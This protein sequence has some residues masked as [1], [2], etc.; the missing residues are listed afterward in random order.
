MFLPILP[1]V[2]INIK[3]LLA[4]NGGLQ[5]Y[6]LFP[7]TFLGSIWHTVIYERRYVPL[8]SPG[9]PGLFALSDIDGVKKSFDQ[10]EFIDIKTEMVHIVF[11]F[12][13]PE[14]YT[15]LHQQTGM[16]IHAMLAN[17]SEEARK[18]A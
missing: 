15:V 8:L 3:K 9:E 10:A 4:R 1:S 13:S 7:P 17:D 14:S 2:L 11:E 18:R 12:D 6:G 16:R 5:P